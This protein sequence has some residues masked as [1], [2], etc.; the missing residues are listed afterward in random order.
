[1]PEPTMPEPT[2]RLK[3]PILHEDGSFT[4]QTVLTPTSFKVRGA[5]YIGSRKVIPVIFVP[6]TMGTNLRVRRNVPLPPN[7]PLHP[8]D[9]AWRPPSNDAEA[10]IY[11]KK[12]RKRTPRERQMILNPNYVEVDDTGD[13][14]IAPCYLEHSVMRER[15]WGEIYN[16]SYGTLLFG[17]QS[18]REM[19]FRLDALNQRH[20][21][22]RWKEVIRAMQGNPLERWGVRSVEPMV[23]QDV[24]YEK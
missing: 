16:G 24:V 14:D 5:C 20:V 17:L 7:Y 8:G 23:P 11:A 3:D 18:N 12:W 2:R 15:G 6:G 1:M 22:Q 9:P 4:G 10:F 13:L 21:R 19:T